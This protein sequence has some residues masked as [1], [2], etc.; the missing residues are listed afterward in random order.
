M[1]EKMFIAYCQLIAHHAAQKAQAEMWQDQKKEFRRQSRYLKK[2]MKEFKEFLEKNR[3][4]DTNI[5]GV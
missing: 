3:F 5:P 2:Y 1:N 4:W